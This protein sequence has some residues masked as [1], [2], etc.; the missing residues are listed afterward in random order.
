[1]TTGMI[2]KV[3]QLS[4]SD[5][6]VQIVPEVPTVLRGMSVVLVI[7]A[8]K[9]LIALRGFFRHLIRP[10]KVW[11]VFDFFQ[12]LIHWFSEYSA[13]SLCVS[14]LRLPCEISLQAIAVISVRPEIPFLLRDKILFS[15]ALQLVFLYPF[16]LID[17]IHQLAHTSGR[18]TSQ[19]L[20]QAVLGW[21]SS[22]PHSNTFFS[23]I[24]FLTHFLLH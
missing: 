24:A 19:R 10:P 14:C 7:L 22:T 23:L 11:F 17:S 5:Q 15:L 8:I 1:M 9:V 3:L 21:S 2:Q 6:L 16:I 20:P 13:D 4:F 12:H 18:L